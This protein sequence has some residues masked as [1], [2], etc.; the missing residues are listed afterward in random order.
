MQF[1]SVFVGFLLGDLEIVFAD[2]DQEVHVQA[3]NA[4]SIPMKEFSGHSLDKWHL[5]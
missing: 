2:F 3:I 5:I 1:K 4:S